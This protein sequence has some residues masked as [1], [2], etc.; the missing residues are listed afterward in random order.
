LQNYL[1]KIQPG[2]QD[3]LEDGRKTL[4][5]FHRY[6]IEIT[7]GLG[8]YFFETYGSP[9]YSRHSLRI[10]KSRNAPLAGEFPRAKSSPIVSISSTG[11]GPFNCS[12]QN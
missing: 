11:I 10:V 5:K 4:L 3:F 1:E 6:P 9:P 12:I 7:L 2:L 8:Q